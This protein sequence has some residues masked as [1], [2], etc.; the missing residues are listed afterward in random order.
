MKEEELNI[1]TLLCNNCYNFYDFSYCCNGLLMKVDVVYMV[2]IV[3][4]ISVIYAM[5]MV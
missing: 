1:I 5:G 4:L 3:E 2:N